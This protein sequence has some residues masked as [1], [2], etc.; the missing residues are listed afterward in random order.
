MTIGLGLRY[1]QPAVGAFTIPGVVLVGSALGHLPFEQVVGTYWLVGLVIAGLGAAG[2][3]QRVIARL[4]F[5]IMMGMVAGVL[6]PFALAVVRALQD[7]PVLCGIAAV[8]FAAATVVPG[9]RRVPPVLA[10]VAA[11][12]LAAAGLG[13]VDWSAF[14]A[15]LAGPQLV[16]PVFTPIAAVELVVPLVLVVVAAQNVQGFAAL[17]AAG[18]DPPVTALTTASGVGTLASALAGGHPACIAGPSTALVSSA[19][20]G[21]LEGRYAASVALGGL[22]IATGLLAPVAAAL[23]RIVPKPLV[24]T[25][26][27]LA[28]LPVLA[29]F[30]HQAFGGRH[31]LGALAA[32]LVTIS[33]L[34]LARVAAPFWALIVG[35]AASW[36]FDRADSGGGP[37]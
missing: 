14:G 24:D 9:V 12:L 17:R 15:R 25:L 21:P 32:F 29:Q 11:G 18:Y 34:T 10:A 37:A 23:T 26:A 22:W 27:G 5:P 1:R 20:S 28:L 13:L 30:F 2:I 36:V 33:G 4:P 7:A 8:A 16:R 3:V 6:T 35:A 31:R 19:S